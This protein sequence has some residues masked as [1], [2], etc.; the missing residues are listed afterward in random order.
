MTADAKAK[1]IAKLTADLRKIKPPKTKSSPGDGLKILFRKRD[2]EQY[3]VELCLQLLGMMSPPAHVKVDA[4]ENIAR[5]EHIMDDSSTTLPAAMF[6]PTTRKKLN[7]VAIHK[8]EYCAVK[9]EI[10]KLKTTHAKEVEPKE[11]DIVRID[12]ELDQI[13]EEKKKLLERIDAL[14]SR[15]TKLSKEKEDVAS[16]LASAHENFKGDFDKLNKKSKVSVPLLNLNDSMNDLVM[17]LKE[18]CVS[19]IDELKK[20]ECESSCVE[21]DDQN[22]AALKGNVKDFLSRACAYLETEVACTGVINSRIAT[23]QNKVAQLN[24]EL[25]EYESMGMKSIV[26]ELK[27]NVKRLQRE[28]LEDEEVVKKMKLEVE[29]V[30]ARCNEVAAL[31]QKGAGRSDLGRLNALLADLGAE[32]IGDGC[33]EEIVVNNKD[34]GNDGDSDSGVHPVSATPAPAPAPPVAASS[35]PEIK[36]FLGWAKPKPSTNES[37]MSRMSLLDIQKAEEEE[38]KARKED[39]EEVDDDDKDNQDDGDDDD[40]DGDA[41]EQEEA[42]SENE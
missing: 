17:N 3:A 15:Q 36:K 32:K 10:A 30:G 25:K 19:F 29:G 35:S 6:S 8:A 42:S 33:D 41:K 21:A 28:M 12:N 1:A 2:K 38:G 23:A 31:V 24:L 27:D 22:G 16:A 5:L 39:N 7:D 26:V 34:D 37:S 40:G 14:S 9:N 18:F 13:A 20:S 11:A 4:E